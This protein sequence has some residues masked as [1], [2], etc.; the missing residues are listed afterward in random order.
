[1]LGHEVAS[2]FRALPRYEVSATY[3]KAIAGYTEN[4]LYFDAL[5]STFDSLGGSYD[6]VINCIGV[7]K[8]FMQENMEQSIQLNALFPWKLGEWCEQTNTRLIHITTDCVYSGQKGKYVES[9]PHDALDA[10]GKT[11][12]L[13]ECVD[14]AMVLRTS[15]IG[16]EIH[17]FS[18]LVE[19][20][21]KQ[22]GKEIEGYTSHLWNGLTTSQYAKACDKIIQGDLFE[23][24]LY[25]LFAE[26]DVSKYRILCILNEKYDLN[27]QIRPTSPPAI[28]RT[29][30][31][32]KGLC[33]L[34]QIPTVEQMIREM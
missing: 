6:Y 27:L 31:S 9:D 4:G 28:D 17:K 7:I 25:H 19:W 13:G 2:Y 18:S 20:A 3:R 26:D 10:Y 34:L 11:K 8:P 14:L 22:R 24:G 32:Q 29:L 15:I 21:Q 23:K 1:M 16:R 5:T 33:G 30:R 12:S